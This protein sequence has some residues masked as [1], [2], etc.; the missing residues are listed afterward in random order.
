MAYSID[1]LFDRREKLKA[2]AQMMDEAG[3]TRIKFKSDEGDSSSE[4]ELER[5]GAPV[6]NNINNAAPTAAS[7]AQ[8]AAE[9]SEAE[10][11]AAK[12]DGTP[13]KSPMVGVFYAAP[14]PDDDPFVK[15]GDSIKK[16]D[17]LCIVEAMKLMNEITAEQDGTVAEVCVEDGELVEFGQPL[18]ILK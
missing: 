14:S 8:P 7:A 10:A 13:V 12:I 9:A 4:L 1:T 16:G 15:V 2:I 6:I 5:G 17:V 11:P 3:L 18:F